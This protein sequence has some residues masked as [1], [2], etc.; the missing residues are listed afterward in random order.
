[1]SGWAVPAVVAA[2]CIAIHYSL[3]RA[4]SGRLGDTLAALVLETSAAMGIL[5]AYLIGL[6][7]PATTTTRLGLFFA[8]SSGIAI[9]G[10]SILIFVAMRRGGA[11]ASTGAIVLGG[12]VTLSALAAP[13][14]FGEGWSTRRAIGILLGVA[15]IVV[16]SRDPAVKP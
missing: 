13:M 6:R 5:A 10:A 3:L 8:A 7:G 4:A 12:G 1:M 15:A 11:V 2:F 14:L 9:S 16:L